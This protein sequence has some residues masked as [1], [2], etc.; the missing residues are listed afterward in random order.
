MQLCK[1]GSFFCTHSSRKRHNARAWLM[2][3]AALHALT[4][5][6]NPRGPRTSR[7]RNL[8]QDPAGAGDEA[9]S[10]SKSLTKGGTSRE[11]T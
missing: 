8:E 9:E 2:V 7:A 10:I 1:Q 11:T 3:G 4:R 6:Q 5:A